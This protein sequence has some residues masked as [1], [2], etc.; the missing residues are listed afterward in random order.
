MPSTTILSRW[1]ARLAIRKVLLASSRK[2]HEWNPT[3][4]SRTALA[5]RK[6][7]VAFA[8]RV[9]KRH[10]STRPTIVTAE[11]LGLTFEWPFGPRGT[12]YRATGHYTAGPRA[13][14]LEDGKRIAREVHAQHRGQGWGGCSYDAMIPDDG[15]LILLNP[16]TRK[17]AHVAQN[18][19]GN[20]AVN[21][22]GTLGDKPT[23]AQ[24][25]TFRWYLANAHTTA[26]PKAHRQ[27]VDLRTVRWYGHND[28]NATACPG[29]YKPMYVSKGKRR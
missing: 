29:D 25:E 8:E 27:P 9:V 18:N 7:Q 6:E 24:V 12:V 5:R 1:R 17:S 23:E 28:L 21:C 2:R 19:T 4:A 16:P 14:T 10:G 11:Q 22:P 26:V 13:K 15:S 20:A 3:A